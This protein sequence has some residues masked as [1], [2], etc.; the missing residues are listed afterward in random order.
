MRFAKWNKGWMMAVSFAAL[1]IAVWAVIGMATTGDASK[2]TLDEAEN[3]VLE[4][5]EGRILESRPQGS[6]YAVLLKSGHGLYE[7][8]V[9]GADAEITAIR[10]L[11]RYAQGPDTGE[12]TAKP[13]TATPVVESPS[14]TPDAATTPPSE[15]PVATPAPSVKPSKPPAATST[16]DS[17]PSSTSNPA[18]LISE[19]RAKEL[20]MKKVPGRV[21]DVDLEQEGGKWY[22][23]VE[24]ETQDGREADVQLNAASGAVV[25]VAWDDDDDDDE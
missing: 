7:L 22:Y 19:Q 13:G 1:G 15:A 2:L 5:Y 10:T 11:E 25:S 6:G 12:E 20:A 23:F 21:K 4:S 16:P 18:V 9:E 3:R 14:P 24:I 8:M 17:T